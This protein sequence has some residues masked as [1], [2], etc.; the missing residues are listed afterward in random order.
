MKAADAGTD[1][2]DG[3][4]IAFCDRH[5]TLIAANTRKEARTSS[6][7]REFCDDCRDEIAACDNALLRL[8][9]RLEI[10]AQ[11]VAACATFA[12]EKISDL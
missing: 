8:R 3:K 4:W 11:A 1:P 10:A 5:G 6:D 2:D 12:G 9:M 7:T